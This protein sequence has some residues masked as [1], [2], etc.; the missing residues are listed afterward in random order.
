MSAVVSLRQEQEVASTTALRQCQDMSVFLSIL[1]ADATN[2]AA[3]F[4]SEAVLD[5]HH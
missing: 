5:Y 3:S 4:S 1:T 2:P